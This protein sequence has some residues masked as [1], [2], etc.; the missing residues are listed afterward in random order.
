MTSISTPH[1][2]HKQPDAAPAYQI[3]RPR[4]LHA[5][6]LH[7]PP[8]EATASKP[9]RNGVYHLTFWR[10]AFVACRR[11]RRSRLGEVSPKTQEGPRLKGRGAP[12]SCEHL[13]LAKYPTRMVT[14]SHTRTC[15]GDSSVSAHIR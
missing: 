4:A 1:F 7:P 15:E 13:P 12:Q 2:P 11:L 8:Q 6:S 9:W 3:E 14:W 5:P 10:P